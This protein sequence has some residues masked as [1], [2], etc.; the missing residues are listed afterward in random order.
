MSNEDIRSMV[1]SWRACLQLFADTC[2]ADSEMFTIYGNSLDSVSRGFLLLL[3]H[4]THVTLSSDHIW[5]LPEG[6]L[7]CGPFDFRS[8]LKRTISFEALVSFTNASCAHTHGFKH[9]GPALGHGVER[10]VFEVIFRQLGTQNFEKS[11]LFWN[12]TGRFLIPRFELGEPASFRSK[13]W[14]TFGRLLGLYIIRFGRI[15]QKLSPILLLGLFST[16]ASDMFVTL[17]TLLILDKELAESL[18]PWYDIQMGYPLPEFSREVVSLLASRAQMDVSNL[19]YFLNSVNFQ[20]QPA[21]IRGDISTK[22]EHILKTCQ[23]MCA[24]ALGR[25]DLWSNP[26]FRQ[27]REGFDIVLTNVNQDLH[28]LIGVFF[29]PFSCW[30]VLIRCVSSLLGHRSQAEWKNSLLPSVTVGCSDPTRSGISVDLED[31]TTG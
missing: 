26:E 27:F 16:R 25:A 11:D 21:I 14:Y 6:V 31:L 9:S 23:I 28:S 24:V 3:H 1:P 20:T 10:S 19:D 22:E 7:E 13:W 5:E 17:D 29:R 2:A 30:I 12:S 4:L 15:P 8:L 18:R